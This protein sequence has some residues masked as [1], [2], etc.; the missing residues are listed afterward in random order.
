MHQ[1]QV[2]EVL[3]GFLLKEPTLENAETSLKRIQEQVQA[4]YC[5]ITNEVVIDAFRALDLCYHLFG[6]PRPA[7]STNV[8]FDK[9][10]F[11]EK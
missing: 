1:G 5:N 10:L 6:I 7:G 2:C 9:H 8:R 11:L 4:E 3:I